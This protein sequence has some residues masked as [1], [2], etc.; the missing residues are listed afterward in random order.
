MITPNTPGP[1][2]P[3]ENASINSSKLPI[4]VNRNA[5]FG[6]AITSSTDSAKL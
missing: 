6:S 1:T 3:G 2:S 4:E 5:M